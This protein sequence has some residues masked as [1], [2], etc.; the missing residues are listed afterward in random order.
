MPTST[1]T[2]LKDIKTK[3]DGS[4]TLAAA[5]GALY[6]DEVPANNTRPYW[7]VKEFGQANLEEAFGLGYTQ[8][9]KIQFDM[10][11]T[12]LLTLKGLQDTLHAL[13]DRASITMTSGTAIRCQRMMNTAYKSSGVDQLGRPIYM[14]VSRYYIT[15][16]KSF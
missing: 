11:H 14:A 5:F 4:A 2:L 3:A 9:Y 1:D 12:S 15:V 16:D 8:N 13:M 10:F 6:L 7:V